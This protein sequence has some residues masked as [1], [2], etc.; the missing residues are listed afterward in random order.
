MLHAAAAAAAATASYR[1]GGGPSGA[2]ASTSEPPW[3]AALQLSFTCLQLASRHVAPG[4]VL[5]V[6][7]AAAPAAAPGEA[8]LVSWLVARLCEHSR[9]PGLFGGY[10]TT[11]AADP[12]ARAAGCSP[13]GVSLAAAAL[14]LARAVP[15]CLDAA[16]WHLLLRTHLA[17]QQ[18]GL[19]PVLALTPALTPAPAPAPAPAPHTALGKIHRPPPAPSAAAAERGAA[20]GAAGKTLQL[21]L[22]EAA[23]AVQAPLTLR[24]QALQQLLHLVQ[25]SALLS[26][27][28]AGLPQVE[29][30]P[31]SV[32]R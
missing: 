7:P 16:S 13:Q 20:L 29:Q 26:G 28:A 30:L 22:T 23:V 25:P 17:L 5:D 11:T 3:S 6:A 32:A 15:T 12:A 10:I 19:A 9:L 27:A 4:E 24:Q 18:L 1:G 8:P 31:Y 21:L 2:S 14:L